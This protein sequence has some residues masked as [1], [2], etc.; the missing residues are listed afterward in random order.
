MNIRKQVALGMTAALA[1]A[2]ALTLTLVNQRTDAGTLSTIG[3]VGIDMNVAGNGPR[4]QV[5][6]D[7]TAQTCAQVNQGATLQIDIYV[8]EIP[9][10]RG[11]SGFEFDMI[12]SQSHVHVTAVDRNQLLGQAPDSAVSVFGDSSSTDGTLQSAAVDFGLGIE[13]AGASEVGPGIITRIT[14]SGQAGVGVQDLTLQDVTITDD[15]GGSMPIISVLGA[16]VAVN[17]PCPQ[18]ATPTAGPTPSPT[19]TATPTATPNSPAPPPAAPTQTTA[20]PSSGPALVWG[21]H[22]CSGS[23]DP[24]DSLLTLRHDAGL[25]A[26]T[27][28]CPALGTEVEVLNASLRI[29]GDVDCS[30][31]VNPIDSLKLLRFD[32]GLSVSQEADCPT[33]GDP[34]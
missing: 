3:V 26:N 2:L 32:A 7:T 10:D 15:A 19:P 17:T 11:I 14:L 1:I 30:D 23:A 18:P 25:S 22:N 12:F 9:A 6:V 21:D 24:A 20:T 16:Q 13:P 33:I 5:G 31:A 27:G 4:T 28:D 29:W 34:I 8:D